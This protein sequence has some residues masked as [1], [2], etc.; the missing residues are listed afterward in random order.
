MISVEICVAIGLVSKDEGGQ[1]N[2]LVGCGRTVREKVCLVKNGV[3]RGEE[4]V[5]GPDWRHD[6]RMKKKE[7]GES[8]SV[9]IFPLM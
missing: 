9:Q 8:V 5:P 2:A 4:M 6:R 3:H 1:W 7:K